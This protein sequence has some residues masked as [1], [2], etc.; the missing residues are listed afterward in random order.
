MFKVKLVAFDND[1]SMCCLIVLHYLTILVI[2]IVNDILLNY[3]HS[4][5]SALLN[6]S[7]Y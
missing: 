3:L 5:D 2:L 1:Y 6:T 7:L 4:V